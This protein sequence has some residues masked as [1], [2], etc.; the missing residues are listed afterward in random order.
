LR[1]SVFLFDV[2]DLE[3]VC[4]VKMLWTSDYNK[5]PILKQSIQAIDQ[6]IYQKYVYTLYHMIEHFTYDI[7]PTDAIYFDFMHITC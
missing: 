4:D 5:S 2:W 1:K 6:C 7:K 3:V